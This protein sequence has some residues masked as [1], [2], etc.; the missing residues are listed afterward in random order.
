[1]EHKYTIADEDDEDWRDTSRILEIVVARLLVLEHNELDSLN[2]PETSLL[3]QQLIRIA[4]ATDISWRSGVWFNK[5][6]KITEELAVRAHSYYLPLYFSLPTPEIFQ[7]VTN[8]R[9]R[10][11]E[12]FKA[13]D[14]TD[15]DREREW[16]LYWQK[17]PINLSDDDLR[18]M[19]FGEPHKRISWNFALEFIEGLCLGRAVKELLGTMIDPE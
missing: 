14:H 4:A 11:S 3:Y 9:Q 1:M 13:Q 18:T 7:D 16:K 17:Q 12:M 2:I 5:V 19:G 6:D 8:E 10:L 15:A